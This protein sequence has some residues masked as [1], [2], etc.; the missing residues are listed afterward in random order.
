[1]KY[2]SGH[3]DGQLA[4]LGDFWASILPMLLDR[5]GRELPVHNLRQLDLESSAK[6]HALVQRSGP[7]YSATG[8]MVLRKGDQIYLAVRVKAQQLSVGALMTAFSSGSASTWT[9]ITM[10]YE[11]GDSPWMWDYTDVL[12]SPDVEFEPMD[13]DTPD[14]SDVSMID[15]IDESEEDVSMASDFEDDGNGGSYDDYDDSFDGDNGGTGGGAV[16]ATAQSTQSDQEMEGVDS[17]DNGIGHGNFVAGSG[18]STQS[19]HGDTHAD[20]AAAA[21]GAGLAAGTTQAG[22]A[23]DN[24]SGFDATAFH[25][26]ATATTPRDFKQDPRAPATATQGSTTPT[27]ATPVSTAANHASPGQEAQLHAGP[28][29]M[30]PGDIIADTATVTTSNATAAAVQSTSAT[31]TTLVERLKNSP[32]QAAQLHAEPTSVAPNNIIVNTTT[33]TDSNA[34]AAAN[35]SIAAAEMSS[36]ERLKQISAN[37]TKQNSSENHDI[38]NS[39]GADNADEDGTTHEV[40]KSSDNTAK[41]DTAG[42]TGNGNVFD[43]GDDEGDDED[44]DEGDDEGANEDADEDADE[45]EDE[46]ED[47]VEIFTGDK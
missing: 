40:A 8:A 33:A 31:Q 27:L 16:Q 38:T 19:G 42:S 6:C 34:S 17:D 20:A 45:D 3:D 7:T 13:I 26:T 14:V 11:S 23:S 36:L 21:S 46:D 15:G 24:L 35:Q 1:V 25:P 4:P 41:D 22:Q 30:A 32:S 43:E 47:D 28:T 5:D 39:A 10:M 29:S 2:D 37:D 44:D 18:S 9:N 12:V